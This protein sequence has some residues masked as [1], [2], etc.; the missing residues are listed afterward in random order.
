MKQQHIGQT[1]RGLLGGATP[2]ECKRTPVEF[3]CPHCRSVFSSSEEISQH[4][5]AHFLSTSTAYNCDSCHTPFD[6]ADE[7][8]KHLMEIHAHHLYSCS[9]CHEVFDSKVT[10]QVGVFYVV[11]NSLPRTLKH[12]FLMN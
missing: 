12:F 4:V 8:Q 7:L 5:I 10:I 1:A 9:I 6:R 11:T 3:T 2:P